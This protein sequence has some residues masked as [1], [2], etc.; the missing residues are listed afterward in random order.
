MNASL[1]D[2]VRAG[3]VVPLVLVAVLAGV[4]G[5]FAGRSVYSED[6]PARVSVI[7]TRGSPPSTSPTPAPATEAPEATP[8]DGS[9]GGGGGSS[10]RA[11]CP[12]GCECSFPR[13][14]GIIIEC[15][16]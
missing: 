1:W 3:L 9:G 8:E 4:L 14:G 2:T 7:T 15:H 11:A 13:P 16:G 10:R 5:F 12:A 6:A